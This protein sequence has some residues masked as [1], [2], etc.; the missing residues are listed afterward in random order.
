MFKSLFVALLLSLSALAQAP[1]YVNGDQT[2]PTYTVAKLP[3]NNTGFNVVIVTDGNGYSCTS[4]S[5]STVVLCYW[6]GS[7]WSPV[8]GGSGGSGTVTGVLGTTN[9]ITSDGNS[10]TPTLSIPATFIAPGTI[11]AAT[12]IDATKLLGN[13]P[14]LNGSALTSLPAGAWSA[15]TTPAGNLSLAM[16]SNTSIFT[17]TTAL[18]QMF[19]WKNTT[20]AIV[21]TS[22]GS[23]ILAN[24]GRAFHGSA[25]VEDCM[26]LGELPGNGNDAAIIFTLGHTGTSSGT[27]SFNTPIINAASGSVSLPAFAFSAQAALGIYRNT[28]SQMTFTNGTT[29]RITVDAG[30]SIIRTAS[31]GYFAWAASTDASAASDTTISRLGVGIAQVGT[32]TANRSGFLVSGNSVFVTTNFTT[33]GVGTA[34][35]NITGLAWTFPATAVNYNFHCHM[36]YSQAI[37]AAAVAFGIKATTNNPTNIFANGEMFTA[38]GTVTTGTLATLATTTATNIVTGTPGA[39][40]T[41]FVADLYGTLELAASATTINIMTS[42]AT[43][44][45]TVTVLRGSYCSLNP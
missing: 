5:S 19:A 41:N 30:N 16:G 26:T 27:V 21:G 15:L 44:A 31:A 32:T 23:P 38:A 8:G 42:T 10:V 34:L 3:T 13:L 6:T 14:A 12:S 29:N 33:S 1:T 36:A 28:T 45:D 2:I 39:Q 9:Q 17:T 35:E 37:G 25:D 11:S 22:Q 4:G 18:S 40:A 43:A 24:C 7:A 20:A